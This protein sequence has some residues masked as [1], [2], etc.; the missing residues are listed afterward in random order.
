MITTS[1]Q[2][3][4]SLITPKQ[5]DESD[6]IQ[7]CITAFKL[8]QERDY[9]N[10]GIQYKES[11]TLARKL[12]DDYKYSDSLTNYGITQFYCGKITE[13][14]QNLESALRMI[15]K[16]LNTNEK[17]NLSLYIK[18]LANLFLANISLGKVSEAN[19]HITTLLSFIK[20]LEN[21]FDQQRYLKQVIYIFFR[22]E[23][24]INFIDKYFKYNYDIGEK[25]L[26][27][28]ENKNSEEILERI[29]MKIVY[30]LH[31]YLREKD[32]DSWIKCLNEE[33]EN[34]KFLKDYNG[35]VFAIYNQYASIYCKD[36][37]NNLSK[38]KISNICKALCEKKNFE[39]KQILEILN[40]ARDKSNTAIE[41]YNKFYEMEAE[42]EKKIAQD[43]LDRINTGKVKFSRGKIVRN[44][45]NV[46][47][48]IFLR[49]ALN[50]FNETE[51][52]EEENNLNKLEYMKE[53][54]Y[55]KQ[56]K[57][58]I[59]LT[60]QLIEKGQ[61]DMS[62]INLQNIDPEIY[63]AFVIVGENLMFIK[64]KNLIRKFFKRY[65]KKIKTLRFIEKR[66]KFNAFM[67]DKYDL[68]CKGKL[69]ID[70]YLNFELIKVQ[71]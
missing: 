31:K 2:K 60:L 57:N 62:S 38:I 71:L 39:E 63:E 21:L 37:I 11:L 18:I 43:K 28:E 20:S 53:E 64:Y 12:E 16:L 54:K 55:H 22:V 66:K 10:A 40:E 44:D 49:Y 50:F 59:N 65:R 52:N 15:Q 14:I 67:T 41:V 45:P 33:S 5:K 34:Y 13:S 27:T 35:F 8:L 36:P 26:I 70:F 46:L 47:F 61:L 42:L 30:F 25:I 7:F 1:Q 24:L 6:Y 23:S 51:K 56:L 69:L 19:S 3:V 29:S 9:K 32:I 17:K 4:E 68:I 58:Q 48:K